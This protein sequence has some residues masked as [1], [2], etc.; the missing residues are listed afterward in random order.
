[1][2]ANIPRATLIRA[3]FWATCTG[4]D[5]QKPLAR[6]VIGRLTTATLL[7]LIVSPTFVEDALWRTPDIGFPQRSWIGKVQRP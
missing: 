5:V 7:T 4:A 6:V 1:M 2:C 3:M